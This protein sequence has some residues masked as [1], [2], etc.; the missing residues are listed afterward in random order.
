MWYNNLIGTHSLF[1]SKRNYASSW[2]P[3]GPDSYAFC[4]HRPYDVEEAVKHLQYSV[5]RV[6]L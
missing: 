3:V 2:E 4:P 5:I 1:V 6:R